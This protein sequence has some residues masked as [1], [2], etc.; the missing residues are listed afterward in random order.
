MFWS[1]I[2]EHIANKIKNSKLFQ[3]L[4][5]EYFLTFLDSFQNEIYVEFQ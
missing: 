1:I 3:I 2:N 5:N 4:N